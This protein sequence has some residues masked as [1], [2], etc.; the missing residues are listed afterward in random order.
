MRRQRRGVVG[1]VPQRR[2]FAGIN[3]DIVNL[4]TLLA[5]EMLVLR[6][7]RIETP[8]APQ[9]QNLESAVPNELLKIAVDGSQAD[10]G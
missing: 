4:I 7:Q 8:G 1:Q 6:Y 9:R 10:V 3:E 5:Y 2:P